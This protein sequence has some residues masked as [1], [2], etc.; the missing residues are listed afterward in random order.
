MVSSCDRGA[1]HQST[2][3]ETILP[4]LPK[5]PS[6][7]RVTSQPY[8]AK[9]EKKNPSEKMS[10]AIPTIDLSLPRQTVVEFI[11][12]ACLK[13]GFFQIVSHGFPPLLRQTTFEYSKRFFMLPTAEKNNIK[14]TGNALPGYEAFQTYLLDPNNTTPDSNE[15]FR[16]VSEFYDDETRWPMETAENEL[17]GFKAC[18]YQYYLTMEELAKTLVEYIT[19]GLGLEKGYFN[20]YFI[21]TMTQARLIHYFADHRDEG[22]ELVN[23]GKPRIGAGLHSDWGLFTVLSQDDVGGLEV[24]DPDS[25]SFIPVRIVYF[26]QRSGSVFLL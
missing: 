12:T 1:S 8:A 26:V 20:E 11:R 7:L 17:I 9:E 4:F 16:I 24:Y 23:D 19:E 22:G 25:E 21:R 14:V 15:G 6:C 3:P 13:H 5:R 18:C 2:T 10:T